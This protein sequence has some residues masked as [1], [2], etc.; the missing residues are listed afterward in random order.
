VPPEVTEE[1]TKS[2]VISNLS[3]EDISEADEEP[4]LKKDNPMMHSMIDLVDTQKDHDSQIQLLTQLMMDKEKVYVDKINK[5]KEKIGQEEKLRQQLSLS[6]IEK[7]EVLKKSSEYALQQ[8]ILV[9]GLQH[10]IQN[11][12]DEKIPILESI[13]KLKATIEKLESE[14]SVLHDDLHKRDQKI[15][16]LKKEIA[17]LENNLAQFSGDKN[18]INCMIEDKEKITQLESENSRLKEKMILLNGSLKSRD[19]MILTLQS[20]ANGSAGLFSCCFGGSTADE[21]VPLLKK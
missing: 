4:V 19:E 7:N 21:A 6:E 12:R 17:I 14:K 10:K 15:E 9:E 18:V 13:G 16:E 20:K 11:L 1:M 8:N 5:L 2:N 3:E